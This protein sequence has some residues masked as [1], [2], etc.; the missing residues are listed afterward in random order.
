MEK[1]F[2]YLP[3]EVFTENIKIKDIGNTIIE[4]KDNKDICTYLTIQ[5]EDG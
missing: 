4:G 1:S 3:T 5:T 2:E